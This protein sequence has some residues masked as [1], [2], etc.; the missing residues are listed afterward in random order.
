MSGTSMLGCVTLMLFAWVAPVVA[1]ENDVERGL[2]PELARKL[3]PAASGIRNADFETLSIY[4]RRDVVQSQSLSLALLTLRPPVNRDGATDEEFRYLGDQ[5]NLSDVVQAMWISKDQGYASFIQPKYIT[6]CTCKS[7]ADRAEGVVTFKSE[8]FAGRIPFVAMATKESWII[9]EFRLPHYQFRVVRDKD[10]VW[11]QEALNV[12]PMGALRGREQKEEVES[13]EGEWTVVAWEIDGGTTPS[14][15]YEGKKVVIKGGEIRLTIDLFLSDRFS[16]QLNSNRAPKEINL[17]ALDG[18]LKGTT[19]PGIYEVDGQRLRICMGMKVRPT[20]FVTTPVSDFVMMT[21]ERDVPAA[22]GSMDKDRDSQQ[23]QDDARRDIEK[24]T[25]KYKQYGQPGGTDKLLAKFLKAD[26]G[27]TLDIVAACDVEDDVRLRADGYNEVI[28]AHMTKKGQKDFLAA[29]EKK[30]REQWNR[31]SPEERSRLS[32]VVPY[33]ERTVSLMAENLP[34][35]DVLMKIATSAD[36]GIELDTDA[37]AQA[38]LSLD[39]RV[40]TK[41][42]EVPLAR[43]IGYLI[44]SNAHPTVLCEVRRGRLVFTTLAV[45]QASIAAT[46]PEWMKPLYNKGLLATLDDEDQVATVT[47]GSLVTDD[48]LSKLASLPKLRELNLDSTKDITPAGLVHLGQMSR[49]EKL[50]LFQVNID[51]GLGDDILRSI[52]GHQTLRE[53]AIIDCGIT[54]AGVRLL[55]QFPQLTILTLSKEAQLTDGALQSISRLSHLKSLS[56]PSYVGTRLGRMRFSADGLRQLQTLKELETL[57]LAGHNV[58]ADALA[59]PKLTS[60]GLGYTN[61][62]DPRNGST[63]GIGDDVAMQIGKLRTLREL[64]LISSAVSDDGLKFLADLPELR[65]LTLRGDKIT[66]AGISHFRPH[67]RLEHL[68]LRASGVS[69]KSLG[70]LAQIVSLTRLDLDGSC[71]LGAFRG[72]QFSIVG[73]QQLQSLPRLEILWL[74]NIDIPTGGFDGLRELR[75]LRELTL[76]RTNISELEIEALA[77]SLPQSRISA[78]AGGGNYP[79]I[80]KSVR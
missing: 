14:A 58:P 62:D 71:T 63:A 20:K 18:W 73:L 56:L 37:L 10:G 67:P 23:G 26:Y 46:L 11:S 47:A 19:Q 43:A 52:A 75:H 77:K 40:S 66:N 80:P 12:E 51:G 55:E 76:V 68:T 61:S 2:T 28:L 21:L 25:L 31:M 72:R 35:G 44:D 13:L 32:G 78:T 7:T 64:E 59:F 79:A 34:L 15:K 17:T 30:A 3:L 9:T 54:D 39:K 29:A 53:L 70:H 36:L 57:H 50:T 16:F 38:G 1:Q 27:I 65:R 22:P 4:P 42:E 45:W 8:L 60:L 74:S 24:G 6:D 48:L 49:L 5:I 41:L 69:D 33:L